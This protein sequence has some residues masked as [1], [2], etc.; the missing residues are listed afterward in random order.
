[1]NIF[2]EYKKSL[3]ENCGGGNATVHYHTH[4]SKEPLQKTYSNAMNLSDEELTKQHLDTL[5]G[6]VIKIER[7]HKYHPKTEKVYAYDKTSSV[8]ESTEWIYD[9]NAEHIP[10]H[11]AKKIYGELE[12]AGINLIGARQDPTFENQHTFRISAPNKKH[13]DKARDIIWGHNG[14]ASVEVTKR[15]RD[16]LDE[17]SIKPQVKPTSFASV[18]NKIYSRQEE[19]TAAGA[20]SESELNEGIN[21]VL[22]N[23]HTGQRVVIKREHAEMYPPRDGWQPISSVQTESVKVVDTVPKHL[24][25]F[26]TTD[27]KGNSRHFDIYHKNGSNW[28]EITG[29]T[30]MHA[31]AVFLNGKIGDFEAEQH[32]HAIANMVGAG[33]HGRALE[34]LNKY[35]TLTWNAPSH[36]ADKTY[37]MNEGSDC[38]KEQ[39]EEVEGVVVPSAQK[40][41][42]QFDRKMKQHEA[43]QKKLAGPSLAKEETDRMSQYVELIN[44]DLKNSRY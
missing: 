33:E 25:T 24:I 37:K 39:I 42:L 8:M 11:K 32:A 21:L 40:R 44:Q 4:W 43:E 35:S 18:L 5:G 41:R 6:N 3:V 14:G 23:R 20:L 26:K 9:L 15:N 16:E 31:N 28:Y 7:D 38:E 27:H 1:M 22:V 2:H 12:N 17:S 29:P 13:I 30:A 36:Y 19:S 10:Y 34:Y